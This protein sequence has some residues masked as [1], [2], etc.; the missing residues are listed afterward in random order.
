MARDVRW[1]IDDVV[2]DGLASGQPTWSIGSE[3]TLQFY[4]MEDTIANRP[5]HDHAYEFTYG[6]ALPA[7]YGDNAGGSMGTYLFPTTHGTVERPDAY[8][9]PRDSPYGRLREY[10]RYSGSS[11]VDISIDG[12]PM[13][14]ETI[15]V[16][17]DIR[18]FVV[19]IDPVGN[20]IEW[21]EGAWV[22]I[23]D[24]NDVSVVADLDAWLVIELEVV[25]LAP[26]T[27]Y[28]SRAALEQDMTPPVVP[29]L[30]E[31][32]DT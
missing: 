12:V 6:G 7:S 26:L 4:V 1:R 22:L 23:T 17:S 28:D 10:M 16:Q 27:D 24:A 31:E 9:D 15:P 30:P 21:T 13:I 3:E 19:S 25:V 32:D 18:S 5:S 14:R 11:T 29:R 20:D 8:L 2:V